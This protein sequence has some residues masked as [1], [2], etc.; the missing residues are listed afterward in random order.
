MPE[1]LTADQV[2]R[3]RK[4]IIISHHRYLAIVKKELHLDASLHTL[5]QIL[6]VSVFM[7]LAAKYQQ[8]RGIAD[9]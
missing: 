3:H 9:R 1:N 6:S 5:L 2:E 8:D 4:I 7:R